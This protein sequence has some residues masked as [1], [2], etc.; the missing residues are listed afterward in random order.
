LS[1]ASS[2]LGQ[3]RWLYAGS[4]DEIDIFLDNS[5]FKRTGNN[6]DVW[7]EYR[8]KS[9]KKFSQIS[10]LF[11]IDC[12]QRTRQAKT[13]VTYG[14]KQE[15]I[16]TESSFHAVEQTVPGTVGEYVWGGACAVEATPYGLE[17][18]QALG[19]RLR[20][21][22]PDFDVKFSGF[23]EKVARIQATVPPTLWAEAIELEWSM[24]PPLPKR[25]PL[26]VSPEKIR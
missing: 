14:L 17:R 12:V 8:F 13:V 7:A 15:V 1:A 16:S 10:T 3:D 11:R 4:S 19:D 9:P 23:R 2:A 21:E 20:S 24:I 25:P 5:T 18:V 26:S 6:V 22:D